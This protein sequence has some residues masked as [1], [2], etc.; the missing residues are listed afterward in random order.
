MISGAL[1]LVFPYAAL[2]LVFLYAALELVFLCAAL[3]L[4]FLYAALELVFSLLALCVCFGCSRAQE[5]ALRVFMVAA[6][7]SSDC[8][9]QLRHMRIPEQL[10]GLQDWLPDHVRCLVRQQDTAVSAVA[11]KVRCLVRQHDTALSA[12]AA[13]P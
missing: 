7:A 4:V 9:A 13:F 11:A 12:V 2:D 1:A 6:K 3:E 8:A 10:E 5:V